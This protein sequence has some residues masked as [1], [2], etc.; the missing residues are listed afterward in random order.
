M[1]EKEVVLR[2]LESTSQNIVEEFTHDQGEGAGLEGER[3]EGEEK[4]VIEKVHMY[5]GVSLSGHL[6]IQDT[7][8]LYINRTLFSIFV[9]LTTSELFFCRWCALKRDGMRSNADCQYRSNN[10]KNP[11]QDLTRS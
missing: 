6:S 4:D 5:F 1:A 11:V 7:S 9:Y 3:E 10:M 8:I 2:A